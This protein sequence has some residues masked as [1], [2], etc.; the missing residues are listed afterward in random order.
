L[1]PAK[2]VKT[3]PNASALKRSRGVPVHS[4]ALV[5]ITV[6]RRPSRLASR[7]SSG[8]ESSQLTKPWIPNQLAPAGVKS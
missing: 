5:I 7:N 3:P 8:T 1:A 2:P 6:S 4:G